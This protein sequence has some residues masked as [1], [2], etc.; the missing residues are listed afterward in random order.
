MVI[1]HISSAPLRFTGITIEFDTYGSFSGYISCNS[2]TGT[3]QVDGL[4][5][6]ISEVKS[7]GLSCSDPRSVMK[8]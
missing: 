1:S 5:V 7:E 8:Q 3:W 4:H 6:S 2:Y